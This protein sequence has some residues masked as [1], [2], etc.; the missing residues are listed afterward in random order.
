MQEFFAH[1]I[2]AILYKENFVNIA[3]FMLIGKFET[4]LTLCLYPT[5]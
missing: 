1:C 2:A 5:L 4:L 3:L